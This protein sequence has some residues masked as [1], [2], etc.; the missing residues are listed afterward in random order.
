MDQE[1]EFMS[2]L[3][4]A[5][6]IKVHGEYLRSLISILS[7]LKATKHMYITKKT[8][9]EV[10]SVKLSDGNEYNLDEVMAFGFPERHT[11]A[12]QDY[13]RLTKIIDLLKGQI[14]DIEK[15]IKFQRKKLKELQKL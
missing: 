4:K 15:Q 1:I 9:R 7:Y 8:L 10:Q 13:K 6:K 5:D 11:V 14:T 3:N 12:N 2:N